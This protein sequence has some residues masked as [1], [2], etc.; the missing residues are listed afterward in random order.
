[1]LENFPPAEGRPVSGVRGGGSPPALFLTISYI[2]FY[3]LNLKGLTTLNNID[4]IINIFI[5]IIIMMI[6]IQTFFQGG[7]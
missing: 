4:N 5:I 2:L 3:N 7:L 6:I 1:M